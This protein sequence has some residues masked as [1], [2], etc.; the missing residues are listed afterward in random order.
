MFKRNNFKA[1]EL[2][3]IRDIRLVHSGTDYFETLENLINSAV[4]TLQLQTYIFNDDETGRKIAGA[5]KNAASRGVEVSV[6]L[7]AYG[8]NSLSRKF[9]GDLRL[10][11]IRLRFFSPFFS[12]QNIYFGRRLHHKVVV[13]DREIALIGGI[14]IADKYHGSS[15]EPAWLDYAILLNGNVCTTI[16]KICRQLF[17]RK[18]RKWKNNTIPNHDKSFKHTIVRIKRN[19]RFRRKNQISASY[20]HA[21]KNAKNS[22]YITGSYFLPGLRLRRA[23]TNAVKRGVEVHL[24]LAGVSDVPVFQLATRWL[25]DFLFRNG[26]KIYEWQ[27]SVLHA[28]IA[29]VDDTWATIGSFNLNNLSAYGSIELNVDVLDKQFSEDFQLVLKEVIQNGCKPIFTENQ[30]NHWPA[31][32]KRWTAYRLTR[33]AIKA[34][35]LFPYL[36]PFKKFE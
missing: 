10:A 25:Y 7:D 31:K 29:V 13:A 24:I 11:G 36:N 21:I 18:F 22:V 23:L 5:L 8:S 16:D 6:M 20:L 14:N 34:V 27:T 3:Q 17:G 12:S 35:V 28:K 19:D 30:N 32:L 15:T 33:T 26:I 9:V 1:E 2:H 4:Y